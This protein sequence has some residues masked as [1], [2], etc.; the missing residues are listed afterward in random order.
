[1]NDEREVEEEKRFLDLN[2]PSTAYSHL[3][4]NE[5]NTQNKMAG[6]EDEKEQDGG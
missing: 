1:M 2:A 4:T 6:E 5:K 3:R